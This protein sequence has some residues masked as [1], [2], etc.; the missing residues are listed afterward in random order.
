MKIIVYLLVSTL[1]LTFIS[2]EQEDASAEPPGNCNDY[3]WARVTKNGDDICLAN[4]VVNYSYPNTVNATIG[5]V[6]GNEDTGDRE[7]FANFAVPIEGIALNTPYPLR[8]GSIYGADPITEGSI[9]LLIFDEPSQGKT[10]CIAGTF[11][12]KAAGPDSPV[13]FEYTNGKFTYY[14]STVAQVPSH[15][16]CNPFQ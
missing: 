9:T 5:F 15:S 16:P 7:L 13:P 8:E 11:E 4:V 14:K 10:G 2:C 1:M 12:L 3:E 6:A